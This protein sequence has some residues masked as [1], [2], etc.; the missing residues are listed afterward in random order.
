MPVPISS[1]NPVIGYYASEEARTTGSARRRS[2][3]LAGDVPDG[4]VASGYVPGA[5]SVQDILNEVTT[6]VALPRDVFYQMYQ[7][8]ALGQYAGQLLIIT[9]RTNSQPPLYL[10][11]AGGAQVDFADAYTLTQD[12]NG[13][14]YAPVAYDVANDTVT[15]RNTAGPAASLRAQCF[16]VQ[17]LRTCGPFLFDA[18]PGPLALK[19][20]DNVASLSGQ[21]NY[22]DPTRPDIWNAGTVRYSPDAT[23]ASVAALLTTLSSD[24]AAI[25]AAGL[26]LGGELLL[27]VTA[28]DTAISSSFLFDGLAA[29]L[30]SGRSLNYRQ[31]Y[32]GPPVGNLFSNS[33]F[34]DSSSWSITGSGTG[35]AVGGGQMVTVNNNPNGEYPYRNITLAAGNYRII[36]GVTALNSGSLNITAESP[37]GY[38][39]VLNQFITTV[40]EQSFDFTVPD[41]NCLFQ[42]F[43]GQDAALNHIY[44]LKI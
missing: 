25:P 10:R 24:L 11:C 19:V 4:T 37:V 38:P 3:I 28:I 43:G 17:G 22:R 7:D 8:E 41:G 21:V 5:V 20:F 13:S 33:Q 30:V 40:G 1:A 12:V 2:L 36:L 32:T 29:G 31:N 18:A 16:T 15:A 27:R 23:P 35:W 26:A 42:L 39:R 34:T 44:L 9:E 14:V 6:A